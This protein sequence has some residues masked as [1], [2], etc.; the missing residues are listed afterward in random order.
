VFISFRSN[1]VNSSRWVR[2]SGA[3]LIGATLAAATTG[4]VCGAQGQTDVILPIDISVGHSLPV[5]LVGAV[6]KVSIA[7][8]DVADVVVVSPAELVINARAPG[9]T[10]AI[11]WRETGARQHYR[12]VVT[13]SAQRKQIMV[14]I[15]FAE[16]DR[17]LNTVFGASGL[18][19]SGTTQVGS[20]AYV[21]GPTTTSTT[22]GS[23]G[24]TQSATS[25]QAGT[26]FISVLTNFNT[27]NLLGLLQTQEALGNAR[28]LAEPTV[29]AG[30][31]D[32]ASFLAGGEIPIPVVQTGATAGTTAPVTI[33]YKDYGVR[34]NFVAE[35]LNDS[36]IRIRLAPEVSSL[37]YSNAIT[38]SGFSIPALT[39]RR[40]ESTIDV[41]RGES[42]IISGMFDDVWSRNKTGIPLLMSIPILGQLFSSTQWQHN[43]TELL[44]VVTPQIVDPLSPPALDVL[45]LKPDTALPARGAIAPLLPPQDRSTG[46]GP[47]R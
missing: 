22:T 6:T 37:D 8:P 9:E 39:T 32:S 2:R 12:V 3:W 17:T 4:A 5:S 33:I 7:N 36:L 21:N 31:K 18:Y 38:I 10:D 30:N 47:P 35:I 25:S 34:L 42:L 23:T 15:K 11:V 14:A 44:V 1:C 24:T 19:E 26:Q 41:K 45:P 27:K 29:M 13:S 16:V 28:T 40:V 20:N 46:T 43:K